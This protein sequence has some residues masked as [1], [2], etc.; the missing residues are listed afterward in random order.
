[1][2]AGFAES[3]RRLYAR[4]VPSATLEAVTWR[5]AGLGPSAPRR[6]LAA[7]AAPR[8]PAQVRRRRP[9]LPARDRSEEVPVYDRYS[10][11]P[12]STLDGPAILQEPES[13]IVVARTARIDV[14]G[15]HT[16]LVTLPTAE[17]DAP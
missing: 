4:T 9:S 5:L 11:P 12:D 10:L 1:M 13:T 8:G 7:Q 14:L 15:D 2:G 17:G 16:V 3:Y 6:F